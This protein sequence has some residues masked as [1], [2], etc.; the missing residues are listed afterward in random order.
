MIIEI[1]PFLR[2]KDLAHV[3]PEESEADE[4]FRSH[5]LP[6]L[7]RLLLEKE[8]RGVAEAILG[9][10]RGPP[11]V[12]PAPVVSELKE[13]TQPGDQFLFPIM[14]LEKFELIFART[15]TETTAASAAVAEAY[16][17]AAAVG[18][19]GA[20]DNAKDIPLWRDMSLA[21]SVE[22]TH[23]LSRAVLHLSQGIHPQHVTGRSMFL[24]RSERREQARLTRWVM[25]P[26]TA[27]TVLDRTGLDEHH[28][29]YY[30]Q[31]IELFLYPLLL[32]H[33]VI[34]IILLFRPMFIVTS[35]SIDREVEYC[36][37]QY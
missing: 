28:H 10:V 9:H 26:E 23:L 15:E 4:T 29:I 2:L 8:K 33:S 17:V 27:T 25:H 37:K 19:V 16:E 32:Y 1:D 12:P 24:T 35:S 18:V 3:H 13:T 7:A 14:S 22:G 31:R 36:R 5:Q 20:L 30:L 11:P 6:Q 34:N 21:R